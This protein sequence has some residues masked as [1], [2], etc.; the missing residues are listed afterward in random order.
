MLLVGTVPARATTWWIVATGVLIGFAASVRA[1]N[2][3]LVV[4]AV[5]VLSTLGGG[6][7][8]ASLL[9]VAT[10]AGIAP[11]LFY[12]FAT[13]GHPLATGYAMW[14]PGMTFAT[15][16][17][18]GRPIGGGTI[19]N[20]PFYLRLLAG[21][22]EL[23]PWPWTLLAVLGGGCAIRSRRREERAIL[24]L[25]GT[26][27]VPL[28]GTYVLFFW[29]DA[30]FLLPALPP[31]FAL[32]A[33]PLASHRGHATRLIGGGL[34]LAGL[35]VLVQRP[36]L[37]DRDKFF[38]EP[39]VLRELAAKTERDARLLLRTNEHF[40]ALLL[41]DG[42]DRTWV[43]LG[44][45]THLFTVRWLGL[46]PVDPSTPPASWID[47]AL[48]GA[49]V[50]TKA[51]AAIHALLAAGH[52]VYVSSLLGFQVPFFRPLMDLLRERFLL[53]RVATS[54]RTELY[55]IRERAISP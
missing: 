49:F 32:A 4:P 13:F 17:L 31:L 33:L 43:P 34:L 50:R 26:F 5:L 12:D 48:C 36:D 52:P 41:R 38:D 30:R 47:Q 11:L 22:G 45:D 20:L 15:T 23:Y 28:F 16:Y 54:A 24:V 27:V 8:Q 10:L 6:L 18:W 55:R 40:F 46:T 51:E 9:V 37:Y 53:E 19:G 21:S 3:L 35:L 2:A 14:A 1:T 42:A 29:Q 25:A 7:R 39:G 44:P